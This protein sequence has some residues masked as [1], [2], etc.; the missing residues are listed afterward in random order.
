MNLGRA[1][2]LCRLERGVNQSALAERA[3]VSVSYLSLLERGKRDPSFSTIESIAAALDIPLSILVFLAADHDE[4]SSFSPELA[5]SISL[6][7][8]RLIRASND[9]AALSL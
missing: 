2:R 3:D 4:L 1:I 8:F 7:A 6:T 5:D 9:Q